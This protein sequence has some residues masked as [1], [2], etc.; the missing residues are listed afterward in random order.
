MAAITGDKISLKPITYEDTA[1]IIR[2]RNSDDVRANF[3]FR[4]TL[5]VQT[6]ELWLKNRVD[7]GEVVQFI[8]TETASGR[9]VGSVYL[10]DID[11]AD[12]KAEYGIFIGEDDCRGK[13]Y[14]TEAARLIV[15]Y[16]FSS[17]RLHKVFLRVLKENTAAIKSYEKAGF[18]R[19]GCFA[20]DV[21]IDGKYYDIVFMAIIN[22]E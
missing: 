1:D 7:T 16:A 6:H 8:I 3:I 19:E 18:T 4:D 21:K 17:L 9:A 20:D 13:G 11:P 14:G 15:K 2:W 12:L 10:R 5:T 22:R